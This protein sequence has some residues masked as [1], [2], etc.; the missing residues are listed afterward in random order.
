[1]SQ[2]TAVDMSVTWPNVIHMSK[3]IQIRNV[4][5]DV[6]RT[7]KIRAASEGISLSDY[8]KRDLEELARQATIEEVFA[9]ARARGESGITAEEIVSDLRQMRGE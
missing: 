1:M 7:L 9:D 6:H 8:I 3:M 2:A 4:P 5:D